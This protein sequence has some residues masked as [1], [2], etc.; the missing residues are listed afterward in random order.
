MSYVLHIWQHPAHE[1]MPADLSEA[2][3]WHETLSKQRTPASQRTLHALYEF[4]EAQFPSS[5]SGDADDSSAWPEGLLPP[6]EDAVWG[7]AI[8]GQALASVMPVLLKQT[9][10]LGL[11]VFDQQSGS[12]YLPSGQV[13]G[14][15]VRW[16]EPAAQSESAATD[17]ADFE[18]TALPKKIVIESL[19]A[20][21]EPLGWRY[22][23]SE[24]GFVKKYAECEHRLGCFVEGWEPDM[25][26][27]THITPANSSYI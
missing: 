25:V 4:L 8:F 20:F 26:F 14:Q 21:L 1:P 19:G 18:T 22:V 24:S 3:A 23:K 12:A 15:D 10:A 16:P 7:F 27:S 13:L 6:Q 2:V 11:I 5:D 9:R 17:D